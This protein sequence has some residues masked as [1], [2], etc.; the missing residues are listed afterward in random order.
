MNTVKLIIGNQ[1]YSTWSMRPWLFVK[2]HG[3]DIQIE[4]LPLFTD[5]ARQ[6]LDQH[7]S[8]GKVP[9]LLDGDLEIWDTIAIL[10]YLAEKYP[11]TNGWPDAIDARAVARAVSAEMH[12]SFTDLRNEV[13]MN[14]RR[15]FPGYPISDGVLRDIGRIQEIW[16]D[17]RRCYGQDG[18]WLFGGFSIADAMYAPVVMRFRSVDVDL[19]SVS[20]VYCETVNNCPQVKQW[21]DNGMQEIEIIKQDELDWPSETIP[22]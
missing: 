12:S 8:N 21:I 10:E 7:S 4:K 18:P 2:F 20:R 15:F 16:N 14:C 5:R 6:K 17:C 3:L 1:N 19:D 9:L 11:Q 22:G 13:P